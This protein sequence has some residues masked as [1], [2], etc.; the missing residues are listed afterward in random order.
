MKYWFYSDGNILG[1]YGVDELM[2]LPA[3]G[4]GSLVCSEDSTGDN[5]DDWKPAEAVPEIAN[6][7]SVGAG[8]IL[9]SENAYISKEYG[10]ETGFSNRAAQEYFDAKSEDLAPEENL[11][12]SI[13]TI[14]GVY[15]KSETKENKIPAIDYNLADKFDVKLSKLQEELE[16]S[17]WEKN[18]LFEKMKIRDSEERKNQEKISELENKLNN[19][20]SMM[21]KMERVSFADTVAKKSAAIVRGSMERHA[22]RDKKNGEISR[23]DAHKADAEERLRKEQEAINNEFPTKV[24]DI[25]KSRHI[26]ELASDHV[27]EIKKF[28]DK[29]EHDSDTEHILSN[30]LRS[31][32]YSKPK[33]IFNDDYAD[34]FANL[35]KNEKKEDSSRVEQEDFQEDA[36]NGTRNS[37]IS[38]VR[39]DF[40]ASQKP[41][42]KNVPERELENSLDIQPSALM[43]DFTAVTPKEQPSHGEKIIIT[44]KENKESSIKSEVSSAAAPVMA[45]KSSDMEQI[46][47]A[48]EPVTSSGML[49]KAEARGVFE[50]SSKTEPEIKK[51]KSSEIKSSIGVDSFARSEMAAPKKQEREIKSA[52]EPVVVQ[53]VIADKPA[54][55]NFK[56]AYAAAK[57]LKSKNEIEVIKEATFEDKTERIFLKSKKNDEPVKTEAPKKNKTSKSGIFFLTIVMVFGAIVAG[58]LGFFFFE[59]GLSLSDFSLMSFSSNKSALSS[60]KPV[61]KKT[62]PKPADSAKVK[63]VVPSANE[64]VR[65]AVNIVKNHKLAGGRGSISIWLS[66]AFLSG[67]SGGL[68]EE[69]SATILH[70]NIFVT[71][72]RLLRQRKEPVIY[73][74]EVDLEKRAIVRGINNNAIE[75]LDFPSKKIAVKKPVFKKPAKKV[76]P[77]K[78]RLRA[79][80][81]L[82]LPAPPK[83]DF[84]HKEPSGFENI[85]LSAIDKVRYIRAQES[86]EE[87]F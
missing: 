35:K 42:E 77:K 67:L 43:Y 4:N 47:S 36:K 57:D 16:A 84:K 31:L 45:D 20:I 19:A 17:K 2:G 10:F 60:K 62:R 66:N 12:D 18:L 8:Q 61:I 70:K 87:L 26:S 46:V 1:P 30:K 54:D 37:I 64:N 75:L 83:K 40:P 81:Q 53:P 33:R 48:P 22:D 44:L 50:S 58:G 11:F 39:N 56:P 5:T 32:G 41:E 51:E 80:P 3:F 21:E 73:Q 55:T 82:P 52:F 14:L 71:Q 65:M 74:F 59:D 78:K 28:S 24:K 72:Y 27:L 6:I 29:S 13:D 76:K 7:L 63:T 34:E 85:T 86:D 68:N 79:L 38:D 69:W 15:D 49:L 25:S 9:S 23:E